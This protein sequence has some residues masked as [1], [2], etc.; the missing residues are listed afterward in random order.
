MVRV[1]IGSGKGEWGE[2]VPQRAQLSCEAEQTLRLQNFFSGE[3]NIT[4]VFA[5]SHPCNKK[6][7]IKT[8]WFGCIGLGGVFLYGSLSVSFIRN[9]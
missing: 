2:L 1:S 8:H 7:N 9:V 6:N 4:V 3:F 5:R